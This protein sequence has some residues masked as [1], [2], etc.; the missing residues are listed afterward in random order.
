MTSLAGEG[1][2]GSALGARPVEVRTQELEREPAVRA[3]RE[4]GAGPA[5]ARIELLRQR[6]KSVVYRLPGVGAAGTDVIAKQ[7]LWQIAA[8]ERSVY[9]Q[10][11]GLSCTRLAY[12]GLVLDPAREFGWLF[13]EDARGELWNP[14]E[15]EHRRLAARWL[16]R[17]H[18]ESSR[19]VSDAGL[20]ERGPSWLRERLVFARAKIAGSF[21]NPALR[22]GA[23]AVLDGTLALLDAIDAA[24]PAVE[25]I[26]AELPRALVH[27][28]FAERNVRVRRTHDAPE[29]VAFDWEVAGAGLPGVDLAE[30]DLAVYADAVRDG[31]PSLE[32]GALERAVSLGRLVRGGIAAVSWAA[33]S[34]GT[35]WPHKAVDQLRAYECRMRDALAALGLGSALP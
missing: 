28:D 18:V 21:A 17:L 20:P 15:A 16:A 25:R 19:L 3:W 23:P 27:G 8:D 11:R 22:P 5:P 33:E 7:C 2:R 10:L 6:A 34:L 9:E 29:L 30:V 24:W 4:L 13:V 32:R 26:G 31:W 12:Y 1:R 14:G 35:S